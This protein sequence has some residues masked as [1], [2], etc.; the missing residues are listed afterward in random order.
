LLFLLYSMPGALGACGDAN[1]DGE[2]DGADAVRLLGGLFAGQDVGNRDING[3]WLLSWLYLGGP[4]PRCPELVDGAGIDL[5][6]VTVRILRQAEPVEAIGG[7]DAA[8][9]SPTTEWFDMAIYIPVCVLL[10]V[11]LNILWMRRATKSEML[12]RKNN[13]KTRD[14]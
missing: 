14:P 12:R 6:A 3:D 4:S 2:L 7:Y 9:T 5:T 11:I 8:A 13:G 10:L 1:C